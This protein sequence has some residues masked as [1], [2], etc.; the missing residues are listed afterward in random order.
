MKHRL[1]TFLLCCLATLHVH[2]QAPPAVIGETYV[3]GSTVLNMRAGP[4]TQ[5]EIIGKLAPGNSVE[6]VRTEGSWWVVTGG[7]V[8][9]F[10]AAKY[11]RRDDLSGWTQKHYYTGETP[12]CE[13]VSPLYDRSMDN[14][15]R[16]KVGAN[17]DV[18][19]KLMK[20][21]MYGDECIRIVYVRAG[22]TYEMK[23]IPEGRYYLKLAYGK[24]Y[25]QRVENGL[26]KVRFAKNA[27]YKK[28][29][30]IL[31]FHKRYY[32]GGWEEPSYELML[33]VITTFSQYDELDSGGISE[34][35]FNK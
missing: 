34:E 11:L 25:R 28:G 23:N 9:G 26:C 15:L 7:G 17:T 18:V 3:V 24:D 4:G 10:V 2:A 21:G 6:L 13:N 33:N 19:V 14:M 8:E 27:L 20:M 22:D 29:T 12:E 32:A 5:Y 1:L 16:V 30:D 35:E 31:D